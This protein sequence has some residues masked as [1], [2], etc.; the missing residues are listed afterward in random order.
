MLLKMMMKW[1]SSLNCKFTILFLCTGWT[2][3]WGYCP[4]VSPVLH[5][6]VQ[7]AQFSWTF[8]MEYSKAKLKSFGNKA[9]PC[10][11][12]FWM[13]N[14]VDEVW[15]E[16]N[17]GCTV[18]KLWSAH[19]WVTYCI[20]FQSNIS[21]CLTQILSKLAWSHRNTKNVS[22]EARGWGITSLY[23]CRNWVDLELQT[24]SV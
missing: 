19:T 4:S 3:V 5:V 1:F 8:L 11:R 7:P 13:E 14:T 20:W 24:I 22:G 17:V 9:A 6:S 10:L 2:V 23:C 16:S 21:F 12:T 15:Q 18:K